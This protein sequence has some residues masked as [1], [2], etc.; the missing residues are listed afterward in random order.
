LNYE[1]ELIG[2]PAVVARAEEVRRKTFDYV[3]VVVGG[4][5]TGASPRTSN[6]TLRHGT[7]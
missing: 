4:G 3:D 6:A 2:S 7:T 5:A 1:I